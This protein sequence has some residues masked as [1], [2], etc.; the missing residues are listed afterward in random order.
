MMNNYQLQALRKLLMLDVSEAAEVIGGVSNRTWQY[1]ESGRSLVPDD[2]KKRI[3]ALYE[4]RV[5]LISQ[6]RNAKPNQL[7]WYHTYDSFITDY[8]Q[9]DSVHWRLH[10]SVLAQVYAD[11]QSIVFDSEAGRDDIFAQ[12]L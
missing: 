5:F 7:R 4:L 2:V 8:P 3:C 6:I 9:S 11:N 1:W 10:Q 12:W